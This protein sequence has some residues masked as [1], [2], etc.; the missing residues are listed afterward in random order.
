MDF[1][2]VNWWAVL[3]C[4][5][6]SMIVGSVWFNPKTLFNIWWE[7][8]GRK[9]DEQ[10]GTEN[11]GM[12]FG[13]TILSA[14]VQAVSMWFM[15]DVMGSASW[16][17]GLMTGFMLWLGFVAPSA[18]TNKLFAGQIKAWFLEQGN[19]LITFLL[20]GAIMGAWH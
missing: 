13:L 14:F 2:S 3:V 16:S 8:I 7:A 10:P 12:V 5:V 19:H 15:T 18:L 9:A 17:S 1:G 6:V 20:F 4:V 11:M